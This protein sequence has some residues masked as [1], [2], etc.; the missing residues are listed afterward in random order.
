MGGLGGA[1]GGG[2]DRCGVG[3]GVQVYNGSTT[4]KTDTYNGRFL[5]INKAE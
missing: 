1:G 5:K 3:K 4:L 2:V